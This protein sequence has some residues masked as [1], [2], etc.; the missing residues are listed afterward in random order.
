MKNGIGAA[1]LYRGADGKYSAITGTK[2]Y[3]WL[4]AEVVKAKEIQNLIN[5]EYYDEMVRNAV[6]AI[7]KYGNAE[8]FINGEP[9][10]PDDILPNDKKED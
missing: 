8:K 4:E 9:L 10:L 7:S 1:E 6:A 2:N 3:R 5:R